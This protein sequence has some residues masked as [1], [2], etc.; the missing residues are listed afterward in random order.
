MPIGFL[1]QYVTQRGH[2]HQGG[3]VGM[4][5]KKILAVT[6]VNAVLITTLVVVESSSVDAEVRT[7]L[8]KRH[9]GWEHVRQGKKRRRA[10]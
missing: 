6:K 3:A 4:W 7:N 8:W 10:I 9:G 5:E 2:C 1:E